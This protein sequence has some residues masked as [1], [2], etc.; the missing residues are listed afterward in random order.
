MLNVSSRKWKYLRW[1]RRW[2]YLDVASFPLLNTW[3][4]HG[5]QAKNTFTAN[6]KLIK[7]A[8]FLV[9]HKLIDQEKQRL[10]EWKGIWNV[11]SPS[12]NGFIR[13]RAVM[14]TVSHSICEELSATTINANAALPSLIYLFHCKP[15]CLGNRN[16]FSSHF[17]WHS[18]LRKLKL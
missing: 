2:C 6:R 14:I 8:E 17:R 18:S 13:F 9:S 15:K 16:I 4:L 12:Q 7:Y 1:R 5:I 3:T 10:N 11:L